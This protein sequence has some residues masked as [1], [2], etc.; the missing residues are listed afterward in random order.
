MQFLV[1]PG[2]SNTVADGRA[3]ASFR[4]ATARTRLLYLDLLTF[5]RHGAQCLFSVV[6]LTLMYNDKPPINDDLFY[7]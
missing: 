5:D 1:N 4:E 3:T 7:G 2:K 6:R